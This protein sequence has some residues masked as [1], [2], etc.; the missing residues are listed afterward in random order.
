MILYSSPPSYYSMIGRLA[1]NEAGAPFVIRRMDIHLAKEQLSPWYLAINPAMTVPTL[2]DDNQSWTDSRAIL[3]KAA[4]IAGDQWMDSDPSLAPTIKNIV[5]AHYAISIEHLTFAKA[6]TKF[7]FLHQLFP[8][9]LG[10]IVKNLEE[11]LPNS[12]NPEAVQRKITLNNNRIAYFTDGDLNQKL[13]VER[14]SISHYLRQLTIPSSQ[15]L[16]GDKPS[17]ADIVTAILLARLKMIG[18]FQL[19]QAFTELPNWFER[20]QARS[21]FKEADI[22][23]YFQ[24]WRIVL[25]Y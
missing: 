7:K 11:E 2:T 19:A 17:S 23:T 13:I 20:M 16:F 6:M 3:D 10:R 25:K 15:L 14:E 12:A 24:P 1:L 4:L 21:S 22:W 5:D 9:M 8:R 18:E